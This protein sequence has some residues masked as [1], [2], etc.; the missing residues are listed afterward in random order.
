[1]EAHH[2]DNV[3]Y[4]NVSIHVLIQYLFDEYGDIT[5]IDLRANA[6]RL[7]ED[8]DPNQPI[9]TLYSRIKEIQTYAQA[10]NRT[11]TDHQIVDAA[12]T[13]IYNTGVYYDDC[14]D[15]LDL[16]TAEQTWTSFQKHFATAHR[17][18]KRKQRTTQSEGYHG[19]NAALQTDTALQSENDATIDALAN[20][21]T[22]MSA[23][24]ATMSQLTKSIA[25]LTAQLTAKDSEI[26]SLKNRPRNNN[27]TTNNTSRNSHNHNR[28]PMP[29]CGGYC[30]THGYRVSKQDHTSV[31]C[32]CWKDNGHKGEATRNNNMGGSQHG[33]PSA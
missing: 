10:G 13:I 25:E 7:D 22:A 12:F 3:G 6:K 9:Q 32:R 23:D 28:P 1:L 33:K 24:R 16:A 27:S 19:A 26:A 15:W 14:D 17:K 21:A 20:M 4:D 5:P 18:A 31:N 2:D 11:F 30:W 8:W 29:D